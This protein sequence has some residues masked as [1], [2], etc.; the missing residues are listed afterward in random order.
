MNYVSQYNLNTKSLEIY[1]SGC[2]GNC[3]GCHNPEMKSFTIGDKLTESVIESIKDKA[4]LRI[5]ENLMIMG[6]EPLDQKHYELIEFLNQIKKIK[7]P[8]WLFTRY[9]LED[10]HKD[11]LKKLDY[12]KT[13]KYKKE[14]KTDNNIQYGIKLATSNQSIYKSGVEF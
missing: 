13:G 10:I 5:V 14:L 12:V 9:D 8:I 2:L 6:G 7:K 11:V 4:S 3:K 1:L